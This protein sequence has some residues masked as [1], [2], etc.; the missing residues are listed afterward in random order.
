MI[1]R[2][3]DADRDWNFGKGASDYARDQDAVEQN[4]KSRVLSW[5]GNCFFALQEGVD[6]KNRLGV[7]QQALL[8]NELRSIILQSFG[9][10]GLNSLSVAFDPTRRSFTI[11]YDA[12]TIFSQSVQQ[13]L[14]QAAGQGS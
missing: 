4:I 13:R 2:S 14:D 11:Q 10:V 5:V 7:G 12:D 8:E 1:I 6:W 9:V 3:V